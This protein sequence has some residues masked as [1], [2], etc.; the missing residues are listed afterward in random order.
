ME[1][2]VMFKFE[3]LVADLAVEVSDRKL[4][5]KLLKGL[6]VYMGKDMSLKVTDFFELLGAVEERAVITT[7]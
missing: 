7:L 3:V 6:R 4:E 2:E 1:L 5:K